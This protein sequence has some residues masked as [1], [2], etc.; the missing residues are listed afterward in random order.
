MMISMILLVI[1]K[2]HIERGLITSLN[3]KVINFYMH[4]ESGLMT[5]EFSE[6]NRTGRILPIC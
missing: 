5:H 1:D 2:L 3:A 4:Q 6:T